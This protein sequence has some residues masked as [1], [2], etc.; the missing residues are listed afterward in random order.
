LELAIELERPIKLKTADI[1]KQY[2]L[3]LPD[4]II[5]ATDLIYDLTLITRNTKDFQNIPGIATVNPW[6]NK[7]NFF[8]SFLNFPVKYFWRQK[9]KL[10]QKDRYR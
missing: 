3:K 6:E 10:S 7:A 1:R 2:K 8:T 5:A 4:A 9:K